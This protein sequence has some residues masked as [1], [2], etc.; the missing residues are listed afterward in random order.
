VSTG[1]NMTASNQAPRVLVI[2]LD[3]GDGRLIH[4]WSRGGFLP[5]FQSL[6]AGG[7]RGSLS[8]T[9]EMLHVSA[10]PSLYTGTLPGKHGVYYTFQPSP[11][12]QHVQR[13]G[14]DQYGQPPLWQILSEAGKRCIIFDAPYT[15]P[16]RGFDGIQI[17]EWGTWAWYWHPMSVP[18]KLLR[19]MT[20]HCGAYPVGFEANQVG[21]GALDLADLRRRLIRAASAKAK[22]VRWLMAHSPWD[23]LWVVFGETHP[24]AHYFWPPAHSEAVSDSAALAAESLREI[25]QAIDQAI[26][27]ILEGVGDNITL[28][29]ISGDGV[30]PNYAGWHLLPQVLERLGF[31]AV[32]TPSPINAAVPEAKEP[33]KRDLLKMLR[34]IVPS[35]VRQALSRHL[36]T[37]WRD[38]LMSRWTTA[39]IN[40]SRTRAYCL[41]TDLEGCIRL[42]VIGREPQG[43]VRPGAEYEAV[44][45][46]LSACLEQLTNPRSGRPAVRQVL[47]TDVVLPGERRDYLPDL[48]VLWAEETEIQ[49]V[50]SPALGLVEASS[51]DA[52]TGTHHPPGFVIA[53][54]PSI[55][56]GHVLK[57]GHVIDFA[58]S[59]LAEFGL[60]RPQQMDG[61][62][63]HELWA[64]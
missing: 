7:T 33:S 11:G 14:S 27:E 49:A 15:H 13:F 6:L 46:E 48:I 23:L 42:N 59:V 64:R 26:G 60:P 9:A 10:L 52:R 31:T 57:E 36:P 30:G 54:G 44:C 45:S 28:Y 38:S 56:I 17:F 29:L 24:A 40:W 2:G 37:R 3:V 22:A 25:Y 51:P 1:I 63:W 58:P 50:H 21:L 32:S 4:D 62:V 55:P 53:R 61:R 18:P 19:Q 16:H 12:Q 47:R 39:N 20:G 5:V 35:S 41:P 8:T 43:I 34:D